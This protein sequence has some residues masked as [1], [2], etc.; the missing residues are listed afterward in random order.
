MISE[1][2]IAKEMKLAD[3]DMKTDAVKNR[4][5]ALNE[6]AFEEAM[7]IIS[8]TWPQAI[9]RFEA[10]GKTVV[11]KED[12]QAF[13]GPQWVLTGL[14]FEESD[15]QLEITSEALVSPLDSGLYPGSHYCKLLAPSKAVEF[16]MTRGLTE[17]YSPASQTETVMV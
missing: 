6:K 3:V 17:R 10:Q 7:K 8:S 1:D 14:K 2:K 12:S 4:C 9:K 16:I 15:K 11:F 5:K 13:A